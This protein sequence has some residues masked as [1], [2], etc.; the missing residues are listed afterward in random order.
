MNNDK[1]TPEER[2]LLSTEKGAYAAIMGYLKAERGKI[3]PSVFNKFATKL[4]HNKLS[5]QDLIEFAKTMQDDPVL[6]S[7]YSKSYERI[8]KLDDVTHVVPGEKGGDEMLQITEP[9]VFS[10]ITNFLIDNEDNNARLREL[11]K[12]QREGIYMRI[13]MDNLK[14]HL[15]EELKGMPRAKYIRTEVPE[16][17]KGDKKL[18]LCFSDWHIG[19]LVFNEDTGGYEFKKLQS[20]AQC[21]IT[22]VLNIVHKLNIK[23]VVVLNLG[24]FTEHINLRN[25]NQAYDAEMTLAQQISKAIRLTIDILATLSKHVHVIYGQ[26]S[27]N[28]DRLQTNKNDAISGDTTAY[29]ILD[30]LFMVKNELGQLPN[31][32]LIDNRDDVYS[33]ELRVAGKWIKAVHGDKEGRSGSARI[34]KHIKDHPIDI[35]FMGHYHY[36][37]IIQED[38]ARFTIVVGSPQGANDYSKSLNLPSTYGSQMITILEEGKESPMFYPL[39]LKDGGLL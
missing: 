7:I 21:I 28:H 19:A 12:L 29:V 9:E 10:Q 13:L 11:R 22:E 5:K 24:D 15:V 39:I 25:T 35:L 36:T 17:Q 3:A 8:I 20:Y 6:Y 23:E 4:G 32:T 31:V 14:K 33:L 37:S 2:A 27:G 26:V 30:M 38:Y 1:I 16:P 18:I 34:H